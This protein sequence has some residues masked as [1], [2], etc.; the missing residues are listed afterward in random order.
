MAQ[1]LSRSSCSLLAGQLS[2]WLSHRKP[3]RAPAQKISYVRHRCS[4]PVAGALAMAHSLLVR[5]IVGLIVC[6]PLW[7]LSP[8]RAQDGGEPANSS[9]R[10]CVPVPDLVDCNAPSRREP[11][12]PLP[13][14]C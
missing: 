12:Q 6:A 5:S 13:P 10:E 7:L 11:R 3:T 4:N 2:L 14:E 1:A 8:A 9:F